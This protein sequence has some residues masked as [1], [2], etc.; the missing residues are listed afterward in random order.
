VEKFR[1]HCLI[2]IAPR[3]AR[4]LALRLRKKRLFMITADADAE[5]GADDMSEGRDEFSILR[6]IASKSCTVFVSGGA[7]RFL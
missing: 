5:N 2:R 7:L 4:R 1:V 3:A 6:R